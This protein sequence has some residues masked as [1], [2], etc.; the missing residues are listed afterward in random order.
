MY[1]T[2]V[3][4][5]LLAGAFATL[6][7]IASP[8]SPLTTF[9]EKVATIFMWAVAITAPLSAIFAFVSLL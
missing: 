3:D 1:A 4:M 7:L 9:F 6:G 2:F 5:F 8:G